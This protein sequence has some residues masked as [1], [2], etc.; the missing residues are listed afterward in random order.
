MWNPI[1]RRDEPADWWDTEQR[2]QYCEVCGCFMGV[3]SDKAWDAA[4]RQ[5]EDHDEEGTR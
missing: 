4:G 3:M 5:C 2:N 1:L